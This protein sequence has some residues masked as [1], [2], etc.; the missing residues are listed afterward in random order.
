M[1]NDRPDRRP[2]DLQLNECTKEATT[3]LGISELN[4]VQVELFRRLASGEQNNVLLHAKNGTGKTVGYSLY[5]IDLL[6]SFKDAKAIIVTP[7]RELSYQVF[8]FLNIAASNCPEGIVRPKLLIGG[9]SAKSDRGSIRDF[10][11]NIY[12]ATTGRLIYTIKAG[13]VR[14]SEISLIV[15]DEYD[16]LF[17]NRQFLSFLKTMKQHRKDAGGI[18]YLGLS[19]TYDKRKIARLFKAIKT[20]EVATLD[21]RPMVVDTV[22]L[23]TEG[24]LSNNSAV[25]PKQPSMAS[26]DPQL[27]SHTNR[28]DINLQNIDQFFV[29]IDGETSLD[30]VITEKLKRLLESIHYRKCLIFYNDKTK[31]EVMAQ[32]LGDSFPNERIVYLH[33]DLAQQQRIKLFNRFR[34]T[35]SRI[36]LTTDVLS[37]GIDIDN[38]DLVIN[39]DVPYDVHTYFHRVGRT[40]RNGRYGVSVIFLTERNFAFLR[41]NPYYFINFRDFKETDVDSIN[42]KLEAVE[43]RSLPLDAVRT[44]SEVGKWV[45]ADEQIYDP[46]NFKYFGQNE[47]TEGQLDSTEQQ[48][49][50]EPPEVSQINAEDAT[51]KTMRASKFVGRLVRIARECQLGGFDM[52]N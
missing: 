40:G 52:I 36:A 12:V 28:L 16:K 22:D 50:E 29:K 30:L 21:S 26:Y 1:M 46:S 5:I 35:G 31:G 43:G 38:V 3:A 11:Y 17:D 51:L 15:L 39:Y 25:D 7:S 6:A 24:R 8:N 34:A 13:I 44:G 27:E 37:R 9:F 33:G 14:L 19:A 18:R 47:N 10:G 23:Q 48:R 20:A 45:D 4:T 32:D 49:R 2:D 41:E 42:R